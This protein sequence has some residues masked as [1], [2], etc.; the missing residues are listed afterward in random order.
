MAVFLIKDSILDHYD[1]QPEAVTSFKLASEKEFPLITLCWHEGDFLKIMAENCGHPTQTNQLIFHQILQSCLEANMTTQA[2]LKL[3]GRT[4]K[5]DGIVWYEVETRPF[6][7][8][9]YFKTSVSG[10]WSTL[11]HPKLGPCYSFD[12]DKSNTIYDIFI[13]PNFGEFYTF[14]I[15]V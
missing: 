10:Q 12:I 11:I 2:L 6:N 8:N 9:S 15:K 14:F 3:K 5:K 4:V 1:S 13:Y 7:G